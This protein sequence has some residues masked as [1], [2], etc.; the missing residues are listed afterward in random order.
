MI[1][2]TPG[3][4]SEVKRL[5]AKENKPEVG[6]RIGVHE[7]L[8]RPAFGAALTHVDLVVTQNDVRIDDA[9]TLR[10]NAASQFMEDVVR[11]DLFWRC[12]YLWLIDN[13]MTQR[14]HRTDAPMV[15]RYETNADSPRTILPDVPDMS[16]STDTS[17]ARS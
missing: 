17:V 9:S 3:A 7:R 4:V 16:F 13:F 8:E 6:L 1:T 11:I 5:L 14:A 12:T 10:T 2:I 15:W